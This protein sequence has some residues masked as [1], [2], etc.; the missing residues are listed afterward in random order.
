MLQNLESAWMGEPQNLQKF[1][2]GTVVD[3][4]ITVGDG[5]SSGEKGGPP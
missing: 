1:F 4:G 5:P 3:G 2:C